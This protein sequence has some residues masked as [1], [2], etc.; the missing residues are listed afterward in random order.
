[1]SSTFSLKGMI[2]WLSIGRVLSLKQPVDQ[3]KSCIE[4]AFEVRHDEP[5]F[6]ATIW[7]VQHGFVLARDET[8]R[9]AGI[10]TASDPRVQ[11][12]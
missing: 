4:A 2:S 8:K 12:R 1:M 5:H 3:V 7:I 11:R 6:S 10:V 9:V